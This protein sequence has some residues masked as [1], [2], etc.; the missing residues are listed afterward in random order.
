MPRPSDLPFGSEFSPSQIELPRLLDLVMQHNG[1]W[2]ALEAAILAKYFSSH[3]GGDQTG[4]DDR[5]DSNEAGSRNRAKLA[6]NCKLGLQAYGIIDKAGT[7]TQFGQYLYD[8]RADEQQLYAALAKHILLQLNGLN[9]VQCIQDMQVSGETPDLVKL[10]AWLEDRG[11]HF[12]SGGKHPSMMRLWLQKAGVFAEG[13]RV[14]EGRLQA[15]L[16]TSTEELEA[17][18]GLTREQK[19]FLRALVNMDG[20]GPHAWN[21]VTPLAAATYGVKF[22]EKNVPKQVL[23]PLE[24]AGFIKTTATTGGRGARA[25]DVGITDK[26]IADVL[27]PLLNQL[28]QQVHS[29]LRPLLRKPLADILTEIGDESRHIA[30]LALEALAFKLMRLLDMTYV[31]TRLRGAATGGAEVDLVFESARLVFSRWQVQCKNTNRVSLDDVAKEVGLTH[32]LKSAVVVMVTTGTI[33]PEARRYA[34]KIMT[35]SN[36]SIVMVDGS[37]LGRI[38]ADNAAI[39]EVF[40]R[41]AQFAMRLKALESL[42]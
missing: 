23:Q 34:N 6:N 22:N 3:A 38:T 7:V 9:L 16:G 13:W 15:I 14:D 24:K 31:A 17:L 11:I 5:A 32:F 2:R 4:T 29:E 10:R 28:D 26:L 37:D 21:K 40:N 39:V 8:L 25:F 1:N 30:G 33:G 35:D 12:P 27:T 19:A 18:A 20:D 41:E 42:E 36:L